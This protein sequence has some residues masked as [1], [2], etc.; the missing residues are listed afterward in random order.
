M[1][2][3]FVHEKHNCFNKTIPGILI[4]KLVSL[5]KI[6]TMGPNHQLLSFHTFSWLAVKFRGVIC[7]SNSD[8]R[9]DSYETIEDLHPLFTK[10]SLQN[11]KS[12]FLF[13]SYQKS[14]GPTIHVCM[15]V[16]K[17]II[18]QIQ[19]TVYSPQSLFIVLSLSH[20]L[21]SLLPFKSLNDLLPTWNGMKRTKMSLFVV[22]LIKN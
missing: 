13:I 22:I 1:T 21:Q 11:V 7:I 4:L 20:R 12:Y 16:T 15:D 9:F 18:P 10:I 2:Q 5:I 6:L 3:Q 19:Y 17:D 8:E 14:K